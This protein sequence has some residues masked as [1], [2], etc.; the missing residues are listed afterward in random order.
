[1]RTTWENSRF[2][3]GVIATIVVAA[4]FWPGPGDAQRYVPMPDKD[5]PKLRYAD[6]LESLNDRCIVRKAKLNPRMRPVYV[7]GQPIGFC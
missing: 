5:H 3:R 1:M 4:F 2:A 7:N 6:S